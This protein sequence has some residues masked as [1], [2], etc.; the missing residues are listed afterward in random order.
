ML[1]PTSL[2]PV[3]GLA[4]KMFPENRYC[5]ARLIEVWSSLKPVNPNWNFL[6][7][8][9]NSSRYRVFSPKTTPLVPSE[10][11]YL[12]TTISDTPLNRNALKPIFAT[13]ELL[14]M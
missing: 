12:S 13:S 14:S 8:E 9:T 5:P 6:F 1:V 2:N 11:R 10:G 7:V 4:Y 3:L